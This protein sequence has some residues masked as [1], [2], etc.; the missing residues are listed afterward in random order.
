MGLLDKTEKKEKDEK[1]PKL[2]FEEPPEQEDAEKIIAPAVKPI[3]IQ[4]KAKSKKLAEHVSLETGKLHVHR[5][6]GDLIK[7]EI[8]KRIELPQ[9][10]LPSVPAA[11]DIL[12]IKAA[13]ESTLKREQPKISKQEITEE[14]V[15]TGIIGLDDVIEGG[16]RTGS[17]SI[18]GGGAGS[19]K[20]I[21][22][23]QFLVRGIELYNE[24]GIYISF[25]E[26]EEKILEDL[27]RL[28]WNLEQKIK[29]KKLIIL[30]YT[31]EQVEKVL[32]AGGGIVRDAIE[33]IGARRIVLDSLTAFTLLHENELAK[34]KAVLKLFDAIY[35]WRC[36]A[37]LTLEQEPDP[38]KH[39]SAI[40][41]FESDGVIL[42]YNVRKGDV[43]ERSLEVFKMRGVHHAAKIFPMKID[44]Q[45]IRIFPEEEVF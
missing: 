17:V 41:E 40:M 3:F 45:G 13:A 9:K 12:K 19:G 44:N 7:E 39:T 37:L 28:N 25:E 4:Q 23:M 34:R 24:P 27:R 32:E 33:S 15:P 26:N 1:K 11:L 5:P 42:L 31:P 21:F 16:L 36:T 8:E 22:C 35:K 6:D 43:R 30:Y 2:Y 29:D 20:S 18:V 14:R 10:Q 38:E